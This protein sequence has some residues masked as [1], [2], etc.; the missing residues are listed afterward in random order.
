MTD[1]LSEIC[2]TKRLEVAQR[3]LQGLAHWSVP[4]PVRNFEAAL[5]AMVRHANAL[6]KVGAWQH[7]VELERAK[8][9]LRR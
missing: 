7:F 1:K 9:A 5:R 6:I 8:E 3:K 4:M 2:A